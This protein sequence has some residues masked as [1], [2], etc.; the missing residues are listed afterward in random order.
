MTLATLAHKMMLTVTQAVA[1]PAVIDTAAESQNI[2]RD[3]MI[4]HCTRSSEVCEYL[5][6]ICRTVTN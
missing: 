2:T 4:S 1:L 3:A 5:A 6:S